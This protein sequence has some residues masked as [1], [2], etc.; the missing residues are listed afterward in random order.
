MVAEYANETKTQ[1]KQTFGGKLT[2]NNKR[3]QRDNEKLKAKVIL[4]IERK[5]AFK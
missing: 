1:T 3:F 5:Y 2:D 4:L